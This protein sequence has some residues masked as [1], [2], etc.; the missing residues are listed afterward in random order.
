[1]DASPFARIGS[2]S[3]AVL[4]VLSAAQAAEADTIVGGTNVWTMVGAPSF[5][6][7]GSYPV[8]LVSFSNHLTFPVS[9]I[10]IMVLRNNSSQTVY[11]S[12]GTVTIASGGIGTV[13]L[14]EFGLPVGTYNATFF[15]FTFG[16]I[17]ISLPTSALFTL[18]G[19]R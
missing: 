2:L 4:L 8:G 14:I 5:P 13:E 3:L 18:P 1:V 15:A 19:P 16:G 10:V 7:G 6:T 12:T 17:A 9:G 11:F